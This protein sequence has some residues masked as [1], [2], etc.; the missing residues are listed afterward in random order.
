MEKSFDNSIIAL[1]DC[2]KYLGITIDSELKFY[3]HA[4]ALESKITRSIGAIL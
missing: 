1:P 2:A 4:N 3:F